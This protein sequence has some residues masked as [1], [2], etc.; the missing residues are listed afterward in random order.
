MTISPFDID[1]LIV[2][3]IAVYLMG[4][5]SGIIFVALAVL[6][7]CRQG[8]SVILTNKSQC[9][10]LTNRLTS[11]VM[12]KQKLPSVNI[13]IKKEFI[14]TSRRTMGLIFKAGK[15][16]GMKWKLNLAGIMSDLPIGSPF[17]S[18]LEKRSIWREEKLC[19][20]FLIRPLTGLSSL[21]GSIWR[22]II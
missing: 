12:K 16:C 4:V 19:S 15:K 9:Q 11:N 22:M 1:P 10:N 5:F 13:W 7:Y 20:G 6:F 2:L 14:P 18:L 3:A 17:I 8:N 21:M